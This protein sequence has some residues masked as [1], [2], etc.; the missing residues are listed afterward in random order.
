MTSAPHLVDGPIG[1]V[2]VG[3]TRPVAGP[4]GAVLI[5]P[6]GG[7]RVGPNRLWPRLAAALAE[8]G[9]V[10]AR[11]D[12]PGHG[13]SDL[14]PS[15]PANDLEA[16]RLATRWFCG[17]TE[18]LDLKLVC[19]CYGSRLATAVANEVSVSEIALIVPHLRL[20]YPGTRAARL[21]GRFARALARRR[22]GTIDR[23]M[24]RTLSDLSVRSQMWIL[25][26]ED[27]VAARYVGAVRDS[28]PDG[29]VRIKTLPGI[30][31]HTHSTAQ[32]QAMTIESVANWAVRELD[33]EEK[34]S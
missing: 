5:L 1:P 3:L 20:R 27:D 10:V 31:I 33:S 7:R 2:G 32:S 12:L 25:V 13:D 14:I 18:G 6:G 11:V 24:V 22:P 17:Q 26:G 34:V 9:N 19:G 29:R 16:V 23:K 30:A 4:T 15:N 8:Q 21:R 28:A